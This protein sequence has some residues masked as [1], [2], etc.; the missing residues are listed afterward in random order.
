[1]VVV[2]IRKIV[3]AGGVISAGPTLAAAVTLSHL[4]A[5]HSALVTRR[6]STY[7]SHPL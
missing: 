4:Q 5:Y 1:M 2:D 7:K 6:P 3:G